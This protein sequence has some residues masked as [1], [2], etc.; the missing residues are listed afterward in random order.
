[1]HPASLARPQRNLPDRILVAPAS[2]ASS[3]GVPRTLPP[4]TVLR[5]HGSIAEGEVWRPANR[6]L[7]AEGWDAHE[8]WVVLSSHTWVGF[9]LPVERAFSPLSR[10]VALTMED[11]N[12]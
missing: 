9:Y 5:H 8:G 7:T 4:G 2:V 11:H 12:P 1:M 3:A 10:P 6:V